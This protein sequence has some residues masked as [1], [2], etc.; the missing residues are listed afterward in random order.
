MQL[1]TIGRINLLQAKI[2][3][4]P[5]FQFCTPFYFNKGV[6]ANWKYTIGPAFQ[7][8]VQVEHATA[9]NWECWASVSTNIFLP[10]NFQCCTHLIL[11]W[12]CRK[13]WTSIFI[14]LFKDVHICNFFSTFFRL[15]PHWIWFLD[16]Q[17]R[18]YFIVK[19]LKNSFF[20]CLRRPF[21]CQFHVAKALQNI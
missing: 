18:F 11:I 12:T 16:N 7:L 13:I 6:L 15:F 1:P 5:N 9:N 3:L 8:S 21:L 19:R 2:Y 17:N 14:P 10:K 20:I 4:E